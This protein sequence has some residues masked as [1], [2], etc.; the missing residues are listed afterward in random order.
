MRAAKTFDPEPRQVLE[1]R[2]FVTAVLSSWH[3][4]C[5]DAALLASELATNAV[6]HARS[7][8]Q[9]TVVGHPDRIRIEVSDGNS[10]LPSFSVVPADAYSGRGLMLVQALSGAWGVESHSDNGKTIWFEVPVSAAAH[11]QAASQA[12]SEA[13]S[14]AATSTS[15]SRESY[16]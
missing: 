16:S 11:D 12:N 14:S 2:R 13:G 10:R 7:E 1:A 8:F 15:E 6:L 9:V 5:D 3:I 4:E